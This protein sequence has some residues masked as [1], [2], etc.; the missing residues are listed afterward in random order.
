[1]VFLAAF[2]ASGSEA[3]GRILSLPWLFGMVND[4]SMYI[5]EYWAARMD[6]VL[7]DPAG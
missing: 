3:T 6:Q 4:A 2:G 1:M 7:Y 5:G